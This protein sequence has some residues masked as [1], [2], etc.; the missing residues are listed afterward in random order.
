MALS[1]DGLIVATAL[2]AVL[3]PRRVV[4][5]ITLFDVYGVPS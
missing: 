5:L 3:T 2:S 4:P 1:S